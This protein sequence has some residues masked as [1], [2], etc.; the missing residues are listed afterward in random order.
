MDNNLKDYREKELKSYVIGN[1]LIIMTLSGIFNTLLSFTESAEN[2]NNM[3]STFGAEL[4][5][6]GIISSILYIYVFILDA[7]IPG[8]W[9]DTICSL[10]RPLPGELIFEE[11]KDK[12]KDKRFTK[13]DALQKYA[14]IY[15]KLN[16]LSEKE[17][18]EVSNSSWYSIYRKYEN[19]TK[20]FISNRDYLLCRDLCVSTLW[21][22]II[23]FML[24]KL[25][26]I[27]FNRNIVVILLIELV[28]TNIA[29]RGKQ[30]RLV[31]NVIA[32]DIHPPKEKASSEE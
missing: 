8:N 30:K 25:S 19:V 21:I 3:L 24:C 26:I 6:A 5:S 29:M 18:R 7:I 13:E 31:Y 1:A 10:Y 16:S 17:K 9:K 12:I 32:T 22:G 28:A 14:N 15:E 20:I 23:Y 27:I 11:I 2:A 4:I